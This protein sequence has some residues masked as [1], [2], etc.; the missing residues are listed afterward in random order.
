M[1]EVLEVVGAGFLEQ[2][3]A[4]LAVPAQAV[5]LAVPAQAVVL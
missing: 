3:A 1:A 4:G 2:A 5:V